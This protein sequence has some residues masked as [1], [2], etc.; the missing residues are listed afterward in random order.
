LE[1]IP[2]IDKRY[3]SA[4]RRSILGHSLGGLFAVY[5][6]FRNEGLFDKHFALSP[7]LWID[8]YRIFSFN[9]ITDTLTRHSYF[10]LAAG[11]KEQHNQILAGFHR[12]E[13]FID[14]KKYPNLGF[15]WHIYHGTHNSYLKRD[16]ERIL[17]DKVLRR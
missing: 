6:L 17:Y 5:C 10:F 14:Q 16:M 2:L 4:G 8:D 13:E 12:M 15:D 9:K 11:S 3:P 1:L 7:A